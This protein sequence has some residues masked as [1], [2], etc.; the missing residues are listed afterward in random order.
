MTATLQSGERAYARTHSRHW[1]NITA[2]DIPPGWIDD[3]V[4]R[5]FEELNAQIIRVT[6]VS[7]Q[8]SDKKNHKDEYEDDPVRREQDAR[9]LSSLQRSLK[10]LTDMEIERSAL[11]RIKASQ[12]PGEHREK[13]LDILSGK[14]Q[15]RATRGGNGESQ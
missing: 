10:K 8:V 5:L 12:K 14:P 13:V 9:V 4:K 11:R 15:P 2:E 6:R 1:K 7:N 3:M